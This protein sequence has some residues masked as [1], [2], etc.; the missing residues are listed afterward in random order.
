LQL[1]FFYSSKL[2]KTTDHQTNL[3][4]NCAFSTQLRF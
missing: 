3:L 2:D 1:R 4:C